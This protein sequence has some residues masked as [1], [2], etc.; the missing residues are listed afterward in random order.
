M[1]SR[2]FIYYLLVLILVFYNEATERSGNDVLATS[3]SA[4]C[5]VPHHPPFF[6]NQSREIIA[7]EVYHM[8]ITSTIQLKRMAR[9]VEGNIGKCTGVDSVTA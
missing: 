6:I 3:Y 1:S 2:I 7:S 5:C 8:V 9:Q 4:Y